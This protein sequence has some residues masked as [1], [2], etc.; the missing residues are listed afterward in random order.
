MSLV[1]GSVCL[2][3]E[4]GQRF[5]NLFED[6]NAHLYQLDWYL[7]PMKVQQMMPTVLINAQKPVIMGLFGI[8]NANRIQ[9]QRVNATLTEL[10]SGS[11]I[12][13]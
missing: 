11:F 2:A 12:F 1:L 10:F 4:V 9:C 13:V 5:E 7:F 8:I 6:V 3:C